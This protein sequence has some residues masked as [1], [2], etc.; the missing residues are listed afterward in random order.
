MESITDYM[1]ILKENL[2]KDDYFKT[3]SNE[4]I[5]ETMDEI[6]NFITTKLSLR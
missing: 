3:C 1:K 5:N 4:I 2:I 6:E